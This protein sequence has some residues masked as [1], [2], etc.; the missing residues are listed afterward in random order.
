MSDV[1]DPDIGALYEIVDP[2]WISRNQ[3]APQ[4]RGS[5]VAN[6]QI[7]PRSNESAR[8]KNRPTH[9]VCADRVLFHD[10]V[11][12]FPEIVPRAGRKPERHEPRCLKRAATSSADTASRRLA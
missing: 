3:A 1:N 12:D 6:S 9:P 5:C 4:F 7:R 10:I 11:H 2:V 8:I